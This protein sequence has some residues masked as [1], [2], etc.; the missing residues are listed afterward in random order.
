MGF[1]MNGHLLD[2]LKVGN[3]TFKLKEGLYHD[4]KNRDFKQA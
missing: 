2:D 3:Q 1:T 4:P